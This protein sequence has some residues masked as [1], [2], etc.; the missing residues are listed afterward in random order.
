MHELLCDELHRERSDRRRE[1]HLSE[2]RGMVR[3]EPPY[4]TPIRIKVTAA[5]KDFRFSVDATMMSARS[6]GPFTNFGSG[7]VPPSGAVEVVLCVDGDGPSGREHTLQYQMG[8]DGN[9]EIQSLDE[10]ACRTPWT[11][12]PARCSTR[13]T[14]T[15]PKIC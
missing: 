8:G 14:S 12:S 3:A 13:R 11:T 9:I 2:F 1:L 15:R 4:V 10:S 6:Y 5:Q 7:T